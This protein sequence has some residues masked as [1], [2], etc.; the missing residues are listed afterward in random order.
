MVINY[1]ALV[2]YTVAS[3]EVLGKID[4]FYTYSPTPLYPNPYLVP[5]A[6]SPLQWVGRIGDM[7]PWRQ[8][9][10]WSSGVWCSA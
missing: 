8:R 6:H 2:S 10:W 4:C 7:V 1:L 3:L 5:L 9:R